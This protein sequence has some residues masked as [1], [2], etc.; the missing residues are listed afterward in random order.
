MTEHTSSFD[1]GVEAFGRSDFK[2]AVSLFEAATREN[3]DD[4]E[5]F[6]YLGISYSQI[7]RF[8]AAIGALKRASEIRP[9]SPVIHYN[10]GQAYEAAGVPNEAWSEYSQATTIDPLYARAKNAMESLSSRLPELLSSGIE[11]EH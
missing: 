7:G 2:G 1:Q 4:F 6:V 9:N 11:V 3:G 10:L 5:S 8:N